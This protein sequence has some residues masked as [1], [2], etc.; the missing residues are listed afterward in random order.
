MIKQLAHVCI[1]ATDLTETSRFYCD[2][3]GLEKSF[4]FV[5]DGRICGFYLKLGG[6]TFIEFFQGESSTSGNMQHLALETDEM[7]DLIRRIKAHGF[8]VGEKTLGA[9]NTWQAWVHDPDGVKIE[10]QQYTDD[11]LQFLGGTCDLSQRS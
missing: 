10:L 7:D 2:A 11:S 6:G 9:D 5:S 8:E 1:H 3:L 4:E